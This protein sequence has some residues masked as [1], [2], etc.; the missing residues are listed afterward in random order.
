MKVHGPRPAPAASIFSKPDRVIEA[1]KR[2]GVMVQQRDLAKAEAAALELLRD[3]PRRPDVHNLLGVIYQQQNKRAL[4]LKHL[5][6]ASKAEPQNP[7]YLN[8][9]GRFYLD[10]R[11]IELALP[12]LHN[13][14]LINPRQ[15]ETL[16]AIGE[17]YRHVGK[18]ALALPYLERARAL[19][20]DDERIK[21]GIGESLDVLG[22]P[23]EADALFDE[24]RR[25]VKYAAMAVYYLAM[26]RPIDLHAPLITEAEQRLQRADISKPEANILHISLGFM[27]EKAG[28]Y[29]DAFRHFEEANRLV[30]LDDDVEHFRKWVDSIVSTFTPDVMR[31]HAHRGSASSLPVLVVGMPRSGTTL[32]EQII[33]SH[34][35]MSGAGELPRITALAKALKY[36]VGWE[37]KEFLAGLSKMSDQAVQD[38]ADSYVKL[39]QFH[40]PNALRIVDKMPHNFANLG[41]VA[42]F[43]PQ[44]RVI[45]CKRNPM[46]T[47]WSCFQ[48]P[49]NDSHNYSRDLTYLGQYYREYARLMG[50][51]K[52][53]MPGQIYELSYE[54]LTEDFEAE[55]RRL[56][57]FI[58]LP[59]DEACLNFHEGGATVQTLSR[60]QVRNPI[61]KSSVERWRRY[62][63]QLQPLISALGDLAR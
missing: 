38:I 17:Y 30:K 34:G 48:N 8:N 23:S 14:L 40:D 54:K 47:C 13:A 6:F 37:A 22:R 52:T 28:R 56:I 27:H 46:D 2:I 41:M 53:L 26:N 59:W 43:W 10:A 51:W 63:Q 5:E 31:A 57:E 20:P 24:L 36:G 58:G 7:I 15:T 9:V 19:S 42:L 4:A 61:Y 32:A 12:F 18:A 50:H 62:E 1:I 25:G 45:H 55:T 39:L 16:L 3:N 60:R 49:L 33:A 11:A 44:A 21:M 29:S 35:R